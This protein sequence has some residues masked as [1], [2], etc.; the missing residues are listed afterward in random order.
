MLLHAAHH[1]PKN[2][3]CQFVASGHETCYQLS[4]FVAPKSQK[5]ITYFT[6]FQDVHRTNCET[7]PPIWLP[8]LHFTGTLVI[9]SN[10]SQVV[11][12]I[13][14]WNFSASFAPPCCI[15]SVDSFVQTGMVGPQF[16]CVFDDNFETVCT[17]QQVTSVWQK[18]G[19]LQKTKET[20]TSAFHHDKLVTACTQSFSLVLPRYGANISNALVHLTNVLEPITQP[21]LTEDPDPEPAPAEDQVD[22][23]FPQ[24]SEDQPQLNYLANVTPT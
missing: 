4:K 10:V 9:S 5:Q 18:K 24:P 21:V 11:Q 3:Q 14:N 6:L 2:H 15:S 20:F 12:M 17:E 8:F 1:W 23:P 19:H 13:K 22:E 7:L 16:H